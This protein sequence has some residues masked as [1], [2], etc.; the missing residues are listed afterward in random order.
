MN[1][2]PDLGPWQYFDLTTLPIHMR[3]RKQIGRKWLTGQ[4]DSDILARRFG[5]RI[6]EW[7]LAN[8]DDNFSW[9]IG[10]DHAPSSWRICALENGSA[11]LV[12]V[13]DEHYR[14]H[15][16]DRNFDEQVTAETAGLCVTM[17]C[18]N[19]FS[20]H[21]ADKAEPVPKELK[22]IERGLHA[23]LEIHP[24]YRQIRAVLD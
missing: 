24:N 13:G 18:M 1:T 6:S 16:A 19:W 9:L 15:Q 3:R 12:P 2:A 8:I 23:F 11:F 22:A 10:D 17:L 7:I 5:K 4:S 14:L 21:C 20:H